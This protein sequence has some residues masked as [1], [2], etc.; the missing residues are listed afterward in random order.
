VLLHEIQQSCAAATDER[1]D[2]LQFHGCQH[3]G[4]AGAVIVQQQDEGLALLDT[5]A[6]QQLQT[7]WQHLGAH[8]ATQNLHARV[9]ALHESGRGRMALGVEQR[10]LSMLNAQTRRHLRLL[11]AHEPFSGRS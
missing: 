2:A 6:L 7:Q 9:S 8:P 5:G 3:T 1:A 4:H 11:N 10:Q